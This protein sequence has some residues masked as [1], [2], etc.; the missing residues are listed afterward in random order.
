MRNA[1]IVGIIFVG[2][3]LGIPMQSADAST[4]R[5]VA[6]NIA[7]AQTG[8]PYQWGAEGPNKFDCS[9]LTYYS[10]RKAGKS[11]PRV[12]QKQYNYSTKISPSNRKVG[13]L[14]FIGKSSRGIYHVGIYAGWWNG[15][16]WMVNANT[17]SY[18]GRKVVVAPIGEY[19][20]GSPRAYYGRIA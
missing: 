3:L 5:S 9:G 15:K 13:D 2:M 8:D 20:S 6:L 7:K 11:I 12:A 19:T 18:R 1:I 14:V 4:V 17:G 16:G 10:Y